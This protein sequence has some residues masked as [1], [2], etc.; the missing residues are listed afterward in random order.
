MN[1]LKNLLITILV[2]FITTIIFGTLS[3]FNIINDKT[4]YSIQLISL[5]ST[6]YI[7]SFY[8]GKE[9][10]KKGYVEGLI[11]GSLVSTLFLIINILFKRDI[12]IFKILFYFIIII[13]S[14]FA[15]ILGIN[16]KMKD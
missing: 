10:E 4:L 7:E 12:N 11:N 16:K 6:V 3:Y 15:S 9:K 8:L 5:F 2:F 1:Y 13:I 14:M